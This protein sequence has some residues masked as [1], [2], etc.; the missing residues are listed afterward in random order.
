MVFQCLSSGFTRALSGF[1]SESIRIL[2]YLC[3][4]F[5][6]LLFGFDLPSV[7]FMANPSLTSL[8]AKRLFGSSC[9]P[10]GRS[11]EEANMAV[12]WCG[13]LGTNI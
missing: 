13:K 5:S 3:A 1:N 4:L 8:K 2:F 10:A 12:V 6:H 11:N 7:G 9:A